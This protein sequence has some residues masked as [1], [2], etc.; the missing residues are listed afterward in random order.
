METKFNPNV[1]INLI[2]FIAVLVALVM[3]AGDGMSGGDLAIMTGLIG[4]LGGFVP[5]HTGGK[6]ATAKETSDAVEEGTRK[7]LESAEPI[8]TDPQ[9]PPVKAADGRH[10]EW[11]DEPLPGSA[12]GTATARDAQRRGL[13]PEDE[14]IPEYARERP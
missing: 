10:R 6:Q 8:K 5:L 4:V 1:V 3:L 2:G 11:L 13:P 12:T 14:S 9:T 7:G